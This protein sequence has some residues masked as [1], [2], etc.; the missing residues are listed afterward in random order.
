MSTSPD[1]GF[2]AKSHESYAHSLKFFWREAPYRAVV[3]EAAA[4]GANDVD[5]LEGTM[6]RSRAYQLYGWLERRAQQV[7]F[8]GRWGMSRTLAPQRQRLREILDQ[9]ACQQPGRLHLDPEMAMPA[10][11]SEAE[12]HQIPG[13]VW[14]TD[15]TAFVYEWATAAV[16]FSM[17][18]PDTPLNWYGELMRERF[19][20]G[21]I[22]D[23]GC[24][25]GASTRAL[26]RAMPEA[27]V[28]GCD[29]SAPAVRLAHL[30]AVEA[31]LAIDYWQM[32]GEDMSFEAGRF[33]LVTSHWL[34]HE[35]P[36]SALR[37]IMAEGRRILKPGGT[38]AMYDMYLTPGGTIDAWLLDGYAARNNEPF[39]RPIRNLDIEREL[40]TAGFTGVRIELSGL[41]A[42]PDVLSGKLPDSRTHYMTVITATAPE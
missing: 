29:V 7:K 8:Q 22:L 25:L 23:I 31:G 5:S 20:P 18:D 12:I 37:R 35:L 9:G 14:N 10:Y 39:A 2:A 38:F 40:T 4:S 17:L 15:E 13:G 6:R 1:I 30:R 36:P 21:S 32:N 11:V 27:E 33:D 41:Q 24:T 3:A 19:A 26:K 16:S 34:I 28:H 42:N